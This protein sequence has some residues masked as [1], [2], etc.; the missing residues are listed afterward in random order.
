MCPPKRDDISTGL[1]VGSGRILDVSNWSFVLGCLAFNDQARVQGVIILRDL[2]IYIQI[3]INP[4]KTIFFKL[5]SEIKN[6][7]KS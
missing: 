6:L 4:L 7:N 5:C 2:L 1:F 3:V